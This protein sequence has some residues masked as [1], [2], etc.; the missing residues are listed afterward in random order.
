MSDGRGARLARERFARIDADVQDDGTRCSPELPQ[1]LGMKVVGMS[2]GDTFGTEAT[3]DRGEIS[4]ARGKRGGQPS[5]H[6]LK[7]LLDHVPTAV[8]EDG[9][10]DADVV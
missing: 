3:R 1:A 7:A 6:G 10:D 5:I 9:E 4:D 2:D 8:V